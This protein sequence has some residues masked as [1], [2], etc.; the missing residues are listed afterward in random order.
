MCQTSRR[1]VLGAAGSLFAGTVLGQGAPR[2]DMPRA[3]V[4]LD[5]GTPQI[6]V[7]PFYPVVRP[8]DDDYDLTR[9]GR[10]GTRALGEVIDV[11][12]VVL[13]ADGR[14]PVAGAIVEMWQACASGSYNHAGDPNPQPKDPNFQGFTRLRADSRGRFRMRTIM[15]GPYGA[16]APHLH[17]D[18][19]GRHRR[20]TTQMLFPDHPLN[21]TDGVLLSVRNEALRPRAIATLGNA[22]PGDPRLFTWQIVLGGEV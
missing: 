21:A 3:S 17:F 2:Q 11:A 1:V 8:H 19:T 14:T 16:R 9:I 10:N 12:G 5:A 4:V 22:R 15:P 6:M 18:V 7:G 13:A 20:L